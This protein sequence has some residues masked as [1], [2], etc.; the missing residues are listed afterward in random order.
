M[1]WLYQAM[2]N[3]DKGEN[4]MTNTTASISDPNTATTKSILFVL[5]TWVDFN[6]F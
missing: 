4:F 6:R 5:Y 3:L 2:A 1:T